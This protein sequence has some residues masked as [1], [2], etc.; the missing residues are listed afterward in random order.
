MILNWHQGLRAKRRRAAIPEERA[1]PR[2]IEKRHSVA[3]AGLLTHADA[4]LACVS[5]GVFR[6]VTRSAGDRAVFGEQRFMKKPFAERDAFL[7]EWIVARQIGNWK[8][9]THLE[10]VWRG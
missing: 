1:L 4:V 3:R 10:A 7:D 8:R 5:E 6:V 9:G 2:E